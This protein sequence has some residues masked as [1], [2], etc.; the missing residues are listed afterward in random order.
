MRHR[1]RAPAQ[2]SQRLRWL[3]PRRIPRGGA[4]DG[5]G[6]TVEIRRTNLSE[7]TSMFALRRPSM[8]L[9]DLRVTSGPPSNSVRRYQMWVNHDVQQNDT[10]TSLIQLVASVAGGAPGGKLKNLV[11]SCHGLP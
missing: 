11:L 2:A 3:V 8:A 9:N 6:A 10:R 7:E 1:R 4:G 5:R